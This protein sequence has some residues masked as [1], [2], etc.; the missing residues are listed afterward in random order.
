MGVRPA[1][2]VAVAQPRCVPGDTRANGLFH[3]RAIRAA[4]ARVVVFPELSLTGYELDAALVEPGDAAL[5]PVIEACQATG[6][7][8]L[9]GAPVAGPGGR[10]YIA[11]LAVSPAGT[12]V[13][14]RKKWVGDQEAS[15]F[16]P[17]DEATVCEV[18]GWRIGVGI[19]RDTGIGEHVEQLAELGIDAYVAGLVHLPDERAEQERRAAWIARRCRAHVAFASFAGPTGGGYSQTAGSSAIW[20]PAGDVLARAGAGPGDLARATLEPD[21]AGSLGQLG[22]AL[23]H[24]AG[25]TQPDV[26]ATRLVGREVA[27]DHRV[28]VTHPAVGRV[29][30]GAV[31]VAVAPGKDRRDAPAFQHRADRRVGGELVERLGG[32]GR[33]PVRPLGRHGRRGLP[34][35]GQLTHR[36]ILFAAHGPILSPLG[37]SDQPVRLSSSRSPW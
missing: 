11:M 9:A 16:S 33:R 25:R 24:G 6:A 20:S 7:L 4:G 5:D 23:G 2:S 37:G 14:Y 15:R 35:R 19:C 31:A 1:L 27:G 12:A 30:P 8:A 13:L 26:H 10:A 21:Q 18:D 22:D 29:R 3:A 32:H 34:G 28:L 17:G 36:V